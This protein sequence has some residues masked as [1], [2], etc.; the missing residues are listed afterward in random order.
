[1]KYDG[2]LSLPNFV[3]ELNLNNYKEGIY[4]GP[5]LVSYI[6]SNI[7]K[8]NK[9]KLKINIEIS[10]NN[11]INIDKLRNE[12]TLLLFST[13][14]G[15]NN[16]ISKENLYIVRICNIS[17]YFCGIVIHSLCMNSAILHLNSA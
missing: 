13:R 1:M 4:L 7:I 14:L 3:K 2:I 15:I 9:D 12:P 10:E 5:Y 6:Y 16:Y 17:K 8:R 11:L